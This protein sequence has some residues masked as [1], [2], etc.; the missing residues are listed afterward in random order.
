MTKK[1]ALRITELYYRMS[2]H[3]FSFEEMETIRKASNT[4]HRWCERECNE[5]IERRD[6]GKVYLTVH[7][8]SGKPWSYTIRD[9]EST[10]KRRIDAILANHPGWAWYCQTDPRGCAVYLYRIDD[11]VLAYGNV[12]IESCYNSIGIS[13]Y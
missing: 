1:E 9:M 5:D 8:M 4:L 10:A 3:G 13:I 11:P 12:S 7:P 2:E 6:D